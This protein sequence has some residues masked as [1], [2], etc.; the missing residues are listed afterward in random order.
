MSASE[1]EIRRK[2]DKYHILFILLAVAF[3][4]LFIPYF[5]LAFPIIE[6]GMVLLF[7]GVELPVWT[8]ILYRRSCHLTFDT[9]TGNMTYRSIICRK[10]VFHVSDI[11]T[12]FYF[13][14]YRFAYAKILRLLVRNISISVTLEYVNVGGQKQNGDE[15]IAEL[16][17]FL[18]DN[19]KLTIIGQSRNDTMNEQ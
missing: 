14:H 4:L 2:P 7:L 11:E 6:P 15:H 10:M 5:F 18:I 3:L 8:H 16:V 1:I 13:K 9:S 19:G 12:E 17:Q